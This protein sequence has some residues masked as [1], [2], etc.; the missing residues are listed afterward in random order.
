MRREPI[1]L[2]GQ[3]DADAFVDLMAA[4]FNAPRP[5]CELAGKRQDRKWAVHRGGRLVAGFG[6]FRGGLHVAGRDVPLAAVAG[7]AVAPEARGS[8]LAASMMAAGLDAFRADGLPLAALYPSTYGL[9]RKVGYETAGTRV[10]RKI[11]TDRIGIRADG[12]PVRVATDADIR[13]LTTPR[14]GSLVRSEGL[15]QRLLHP[16]A[17][18]V[19]AYIVGDD[20]GWVAVWQEDPGAHFAWK[21]RDWQ[22]RTPAAARRLWALLASGSTMADTAHWPGPPNDLMESLLPEVGATVAKCE[23]TMLRIVDLPGA[24]AARG[25]ATDGVATVAVTDDVLPENAGAWRIVVEGGA[26]RAERLDG[27]AASSLDIRALAPLYSGFHSAVDLASVG[28]L[29]GDTLALDR[30]FATRTSPWMADNF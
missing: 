13:A 10:E 1:A 2:L 30:L 15:W 20:E 7:V 19:Q 28:M 25:W 9:Y 3:A 16:L 21:V 18:R 11:R 4:T 22:A 17:G 6:I 26:G 12:M 27:K 8:G 14:H 24:I 29:V 5:A 23:R